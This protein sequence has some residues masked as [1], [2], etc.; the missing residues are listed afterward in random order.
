MGKHETIRKEAFKRFKQLKEDDGQ[1]TRTLEYGSGQKYAVFS[2]L[3]I[4]DGTGADNFRQNEQTFITALDYYNK[5]GNEYSIILLGDIEEFHQF[6][7]ERITN[8]Y[9]K[10]DGQRSVYNVLQAFPDQRL[11]RVHG[12]HDVEWSL[13][14]PI[15]DQRPKSSVE[16]IKLKKGTETHFMLTHGHQAEEPIEKDLHRVRL[17]T[18]FY[19]MLERVFKIDSQSLL[20]VGPCFKDRIYSDWTK[21]NRMILISGHTHCPVIASHFIDYNWITSRYKQ[22][23][24]Q[25]KN[26]TD[27]DE[28]N[29]LVIRKKWLHSKKSDIEHQRSRGGKFPRSPDPTL[30]TFYFN[31]GGCLFKDA[32]TNIEIDG[33]IIRLVYWTNADNRREVFMNLE[34]NISALITTGP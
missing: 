31:T 15:Y 26:T 9:L 14:D 22:C 25:L 34:L 3:H 19:R 5:P 12:N 1:L 32:I 20:D 4:G 7:L 18:T 8:R 33:D 23:V 10:T 11:H 21:E 24:D 29:R 27:R 2:D 13:Q 28:V 6:D 17:G 16:A 30:S